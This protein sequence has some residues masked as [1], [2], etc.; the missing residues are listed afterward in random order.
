MKTFRLFLACTFIFFFAGSLFG[1]SITSLQLQATKLLYDAKRDKIYAIV[2]GSDSLYGNSFVQIN[3]QN[4]KIERSIF[5]G[6]E[7][8]CMDITKDTNYVY[9]ALGG[10]SYIK[11]VDL[12]R[13][14]ID[15]TIALPLHF[16]SPIFASP[17]FASDIATVSLSP[18]LVVVSL[19]TVSTSPKFRGVVAYYKESLLPAFIQGHTGANVIESATDTNLIFGYNLETSG[20]DFY[21]MNVDTVTGVNLIDKTRI[22][23]GSASNFMYR[24][25][26]IYT[27]SG[28]IIDP[29]LEKPAIVKELSFHAQ[30]IEIDTKKGYAFLGT[31]S[32]NVLKIDYFDLNTQQM[33]YQKSFVDVIP[34][35][36]SLGEITEIIRF[37]DDGLA[38]II[39]DYYHDFNTRRV[40]FFKSSFVLSTKGNDSKYTIASYPNPVS[41]YLT[42]NL[43]LDKECKIAYH[44]Y[45]IQGK[46]FISDRFIG[47]LG[48]NQK[49]IAFHNLTNGIYVISVQI[50]GKNTEQ[51]KIIKQ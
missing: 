46:L 19:E 47:Q 7:P 42:L 15:Q 40:L 3:P 12:Q 24:G 48:E 20:D 36:Y 27:N 38:M 35:D 10:A 41:D 25:N 50:D 32:Y 44:V 49:K 8:N 1:E 22:S 28:E 16:V 21:R 31:I 30:N 17:I 11:R 51:V 23:L 2:N 37:G 5:I 9:V 43:N 18:D 45:D 33:T 26:H 4:N 6:S 34:P 29:Y 14:Q 13:F 39:R